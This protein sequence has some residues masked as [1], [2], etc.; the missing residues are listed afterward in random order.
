MKRYLL[1]AL[2]LLYASHS[3][4]QAMAFPDMA[5]LVRLSVG[6]VDNI[7]MAT[8]KYRLNNKSEVNGQII[9]EYQSID[10]DKKVIK[11]ETLITGAFRTSNDG[12]QLY[13]VT[14]RTIYRQ[15][16]YNLMKQMVKYGYHLTLKGADKIK[17]IYIYDNAFNHVTVSMLDDHSTNIIDIRQKD[18]DLER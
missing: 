5:D 9:N 4:G 17:T 1:A 18:G 12:I 10:K 14:Y 7:L 8:G 11:G 3:Q 16:V 15:Y 13:T 6:Q 2:L